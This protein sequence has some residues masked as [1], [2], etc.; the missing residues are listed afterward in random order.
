ML[1]RKSVEWALLIKMV[2][3]CSYELVDNES[4]GFKKVPATL[5]EELDV[6]VI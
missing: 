2:L 3:N 4:A 6:Q 1:K 5:G